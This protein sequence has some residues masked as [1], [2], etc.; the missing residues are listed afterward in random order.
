MNRAWFTGFLTEE[1]ME[2][3]HPLE[4]EK[5]LTEEDDDSV[6]FVKVDTEV[7]EITGVQKTENKKTQNKGTGEK[8]E[9]KPE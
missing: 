5:I 2:K 6:K 8:K 4:L 1:E 3:E 7:D 9:N